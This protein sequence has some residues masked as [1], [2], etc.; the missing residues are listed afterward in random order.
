MMVQLNEAT[1][2]VFGTPDYYVII[3]ALSLTG[4]VSLW[5]L[6]NHCSDN[7]SYYAMF[8]HKNGL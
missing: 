7:V 6:P 4:E 1:A 5:W 3:S 2:N 8:D